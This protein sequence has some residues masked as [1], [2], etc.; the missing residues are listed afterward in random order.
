[1]SIL[2]LRNMCKELELAQIKLIRAYEKASQTFPD[3]TAIAARCA[4]HQAHDF[5]VPV[6]YALN[7]KTGTDFCDRWD[8]ATAGAEITLARKQS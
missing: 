1:M 3:A 4:L 8:A 7:E 6:A 5:L 2:A